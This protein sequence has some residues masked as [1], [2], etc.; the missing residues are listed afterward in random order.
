MPWKMV[1]RGGASMTLEEVVEGIGR[2]DEERKLV[3]KF[4]SEHRDEINEKLWVN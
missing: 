4:E 3:S 1:N 2:C